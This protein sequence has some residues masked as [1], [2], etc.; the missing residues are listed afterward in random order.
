[1]TLSGFTKAERLARIIL[2]LG[3][4]ACAIALTLPARR[5]VNEA[6]LT[7]INVKETSQQVKDYA[8][9][10]REMLQSPRN[11]KSIEA[12]LQVGP[13]AVAV[14]KTLN[15]QTLPRLHK[16]IDRLEEVG[17]QSRDLLANTDENINGQDGILLAVRNVAAKFETTPEKINAAIVTLA[18]SGQ[19]TMESA[20]KLIADPAWQT[21]LTNAATVSVEAASVAKNTR[22]ASDAL[23]VIGA[24]LQGSAMNIKD[25]TA[26]IE[27]FLAEQSKGSKVI[28]ALRI[29]G[30]VLP[31]LQLR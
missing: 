22:L 11:Q 13:N 21:V 14:F 16:A 20:V 10:Q 6:E 30:A 31:L 1:M 5:T 19:L 24:E 7:F 2:C 23:P 9:T 28:L 29:M 26:L 12:N 17:A 18:T 25:I 27:K 15:T 4:L 8:I 3:L